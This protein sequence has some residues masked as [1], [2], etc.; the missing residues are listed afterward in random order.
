MRLVDDAEQPPS[1]LDVRDDRLVL[2]VQETASRTAQ[3]PGFVR[4][5]TPPGRY[6]QPGAAV[7]CMYDANPHEPPATVECQ[8]SPQGGV[9]AELLEVLEMQHAAVPAIDTDVAKRRVQTGTKFVG[10]HEVQVFLERAC[11]VSSPGSRPVKPSRAASAGTR[12]FRHGQN[13]A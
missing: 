13:S 7:E 8:N 10:L 9:S 6:Q 2:A 11:R 4:A 5:V 12:V 1:Y 3:R